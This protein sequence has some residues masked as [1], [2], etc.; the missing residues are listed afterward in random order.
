MKKRFKTKKKKTNKLIKLISILLI[1]YISFNLSYTVIYKIYLS[2][3]D[4][5]KIIKHIIKNSQ[6]NKSKN[7]LFTKYKNPQTILSNNFNNLIKQEKVIKPVDNKLNEEVQVYIYC[8]HETESY[9][10][11]YLEIYNIEPTIKTMS[12][13]LQEYL[14]DLGINTIVE[15]K[16]ISKILKNNNWSYKYSY[17]ASKIAIQDTIEKEKSLKLIIDLH[18]DSSSIEKTLTEYEG[19]KY[20]KILFVIGK[21]HQNYEK[22]YNL[23]VNIN[24]LL[25]EEINTITRGVLTKGNEGSNGIYNQDLSEKSILI[26]LGGQY[27]KIEE[28]NNTLEVL[29]KVIL[30]YIEGEI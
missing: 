12:Y 2:K 29:S 5:T 16:S 20:A 7:K 6:N 8:T 28:L 3:L 30:K 4:N 18:R 26:E 19:K 27:N 9:Q 14:T 17:A 13:I 10:D 15:E 1:I 25:K 24:E 23:A 22:N 11:P 21:K